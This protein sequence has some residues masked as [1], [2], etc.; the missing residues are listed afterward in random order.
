MHSD[1]ELPLDIHKALKTNAP[2]SFKMTVVYITSIIDLGAVGSFTNQHLVQ[3]LHTSTTQIWHMPPQR[4]GGD[5]GVGEGFPI[6]K[7]QQHKRKFW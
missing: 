6:L 4:H 3:S 5:M 1:S 2:K 7:Q